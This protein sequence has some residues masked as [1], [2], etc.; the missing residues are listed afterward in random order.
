MAVVTEK[1]AWRL[2]VVV[3]LFC[4]F[5]LSF[6]ILTQPEPC[7][8]AQIMCYRGCEQSVDTQ[9]LQDLCK[10][11]CASSYQKCKLANGDS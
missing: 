2:A 8:E 3:L 10:V 6:I 4:T 5:A 7:M 1:F 9:F 11:Q